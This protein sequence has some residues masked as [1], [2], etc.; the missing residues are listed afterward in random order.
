MASGPLNGTRVL[1]FTQIIAGPL[2]CQLLSDLGADVIK[3]EPP[4][5]EAWR[6]QSAFMPLESKQFHTL[7]RGKKSLAIDI[8]RPE[9]QEVIHRLVRDIDVVVINYRPDVA[10]HLRIDYETLRGIK[11]DLIY[12]DNTAFGRQGDM[13]SR[14]GYDIVVQAMCGLIAAVGKTDDRGVPVVPPP[15]ADTTTAYSIS[16]AVCAALFHRARTGEGQMI[17]TSLLSNALVIS[18]NYFAAVPAADAEARARFAAVLEDAEAHGARYAET[19]AASEATQ[20]LAAQGNVYYRCFLTSDGAI[21]IGALSVD[22][23]NKVRKVLGI[24]HN[25][26]EPGYNPA[27]P[28]QREID[29]ATVRKV[30]AMI[31]E[32]SSEHWERAFQAG[33]VPVSRINFPQQL[34]DHAQVLANEYVVTLDHDLSGEERLA[35][36]PWKMSATQPRAQ[37]AAPPLGRDNDAVLASAGYAPAEI[38]ALRSKGVI[39]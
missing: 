21:A 27:D 9:A 35:A 34:V 7:N 10:A 18:M 11:P 26:D 13:A 15:F 2:G 31:A 30:E 39:R 24:E 36:P 5:G 28:G 17:E 16:T 32:C 25:R 6:L 20:R 38:D 4:E 23:R 12:V 8:R 14:P 3:V 29:L 33:G 37:G 22:L 19:L 1:E